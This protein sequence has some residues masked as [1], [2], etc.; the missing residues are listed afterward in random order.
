MTINYTNLLG[1]AKPVTGTET[2]Q[3][4]DVVNDQITELV[5]DAIANASSISVTSGDVTLTTTTGSS[6][7]AR[8]AVLLITGSPGVSRNIIA[9]S[10]SKWYI[11]KNSSNA[12]IVVKGSATTGVT[13]L[14][15]TEALVFWNGSD[16]EVAGLVGPSSATDNAIARFDSTTGKVIQ[17]SGVTIDDSN[18]V[19]GVAQLNATTADLTNLEVTNIKAK[20]GTAAASIADSTGIVSITANPI[21]SG[22]TANGVA[23][24]NGSKVL[25][26]GS[27]LT[28]DGTNLGLNVTP[29]ASQGRIQANGAGQSWFKFY[30]STAGWNFGTF[31]KA[32]GTTAL[33]YFGGGGGSAIAGGTVDDFV[34]RAEGNLL[35]AISTSEAMRLTSTSLYTASGI[36][37]GIG[38]SS[39]GAKLELYTAGTLN[40][41][42]NGSLAGGNTVDFYNYIP[43]VSNAGFAIALGGTTRAVIDSSGNLGLGVTPSAWSTGKAVEVGF[44]GNSVYSYSQTDFEILSNAYYNAGY[45]FGGT[46]RAMMYAMG[47]AGSG[48]HSWH[49]STASGSAGNAITFTQAMTLDASGN[50]I[51]GGTSASA[52]SATT[53]YNDGTIASIL[54][55]GVGGTSI[56]GAIS[57]VSNGYEIAVTSGNAQTYKWHNGGT[58]AMT[59]TSGGDLLVGTSTQLARLAAVGS[60]ALTGYNLFLSQ[61]TLYQDLGGYGDA[62]SG[63]GTWNWVPGTVPGSGVAEFFTRFR[64]RTSGGTTN[65]NVIVDGNLLVGKTATD[66][67]VVGIQLL[68]SGAA[69]FTRS[70]STSAVSTLDVYSTGASAYRFYVDMA[71]TIF[72]TSTTISAISDIRFKENVRDLDVGLGAVMAL[73][74]RL[75]DWKEGK[76]ANIKN[77]RGFIAQEFEQVF[78][79]LIDEW[80]DPAPEG[81]EPYKSVRADLI[82]VLVKAL[83]EMKEIV[84][85]QAARIAALEA[86]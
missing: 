2:G 42:L 17:N 41:R 33:A 83:Q 55:S 30:D 11:V 85:A 15:D 81:E 20:D 43:A 77:A 1:L 49:T 3:W 62:S 4:G 25:T 21:L 67:S 37:V 63:N 44:V 6:N 80:K 14:A 35:F 58:Q 48:I 75:Y 68:P 24:L 9:P 65:H 10:Q 13:I 12:N 19:S 38:T 46:G 23:Y 39:P 78:P 59:F 32:N 8:M 72:A 57:G 64:S 54:A 40:L 86:A 28:F 82:P 60:A 66:A 22:G 70:G 36:N 27:A 26:T 47:T 16:F 51:V 76:G 73:K 74:P 31:Y 18:N 69:Q 34:V 52:S 50:L 71:G 5:E 79:D 45:K 56:F 84:D 53:L 29:S 7:Q 61:G